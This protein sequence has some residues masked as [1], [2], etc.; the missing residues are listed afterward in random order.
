MGS[1]GSR[2]LDARENFFFILIQKTATTI[3]AIM[4]R[5]KSKGYSFGITA[6]NSIKRNAE[7]PIINPESSYIATKILS[8]TITTQ[9]LF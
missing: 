4:S 1:S 9:L 5:M 8:L 6:N 3:I 7:K 2:E